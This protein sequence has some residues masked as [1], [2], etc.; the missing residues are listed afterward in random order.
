MFF[1][2]AVFVGGAWMALACGG[3]SQPDPEL[4]TEEGTPPV[5]TPAT[6]QQDTDQQDTA[7][8]QAQVRATEI[9]FAQTMAD[10]DHA[11]FASFLSEE[12]IFF[13]GLEP[14]RGKQAVAEAWAP[15][16]EGPQAPFS[17]EPE[18]VEVLDSGTLGIS[19]GPVRDPGG[20]RVGTFNSVWRLEANGE[21]KIIFDKGCPAGGP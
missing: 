12:T 1:A 14:I 8:L 3:Q 10:R 2:V 7:A 17:W 21:W 4:P 13:N 20:N 5:S 18:V 15:F 19:S 11:A 16:F 9:A 6:D